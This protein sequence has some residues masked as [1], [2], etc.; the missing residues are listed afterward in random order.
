MAYKRN[1]G[2]PMDEGGTGNTAMTAYAVVC[3]GTTPTGALQSV[4]GLGSAGQIL[5]SNGAA[6]LPTFQA[7]PASGI[8]TLNGDSGSATGAT[9]TLDAYPSSGK[10]VTF[11]GSGATM[12]LATT[13]A[14]DNTSV[15]SW[16][17]G[18]AYT[19]G[20]R[21]TSLGYLSGG[22]IT[23]ANDN[24]LIGW[25]CGL[26]ANGNSNTAIGSKALYACNTGSSNVAVGEN[27]GHD[28][29]S[30][31]YNTVVG[32]GALFSVLTG[33]RNIAIGLGGGSNYT[34]AESSNIIIANAGTLGESNVIRV[35]TSGSGSGQQNKCYIAG[36]NGVN[37]GSVAS[38]LTNSGDQLGTAT[39]TAGSGISVTPGANTITIASTATGLTW[40]EVTVDASFTVN[41]GTIANKA[42]LLTMTLPATAALGD[43]IE[44]TNIN[45][46]VGWRI[47]Q[48]ANQYI[49]AGST[50]TTTGV[51]GY[52][53]AT[54]LG[55][56]VKL[57]CIVAGAST[58]WQA[59]SIVGNLTIV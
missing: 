28:F 24:T 2:I 37:V 57:V 52:L 35:G 54:A 34:G 47:A 45:T 41:T 43:I 56:S 23:T 3:G 44:I 20:S 27:A 13:D 6:A 19:T 4:S 51:G 21:N 1:S 42:G 58:G 53:E 7:A 25:G 15:G 22:Y 17:T 10:T 29:Q 18:S 32:H 49:R 33:S 48:N 26:P 38:V 50:L 12:T 59:T 5:T 16:P 9:V 55:D 46:A 36:I 40:S 11:S 30:A 14:N 39:I 31:S 8:G